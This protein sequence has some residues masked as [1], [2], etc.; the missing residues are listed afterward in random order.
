MKT[1]NERNEMWSLDADA[2][3][4]TKL[5]GFATDSTHQVKFIG[6]REKGVINGNQSLFL[7]SVGQ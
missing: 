4:W 2:L 7:S 3:I 1:R 5:G 6:E